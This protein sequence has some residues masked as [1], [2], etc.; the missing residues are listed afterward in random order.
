MDNAPN[1][2]HEEIMMNR[3]ILSQMQMQNTY[4]PVTPPQEASGVEKEPGSI[5]V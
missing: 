2:L 5:V 4:V 1:K 3:Q